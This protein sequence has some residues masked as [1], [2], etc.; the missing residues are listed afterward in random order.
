MPAPSG[1]DGAPTAKP[2]V[3]K[4]SLWDFE[5]RG[6]RLAVI[7]A[8]DFGCNVCGG[9]TGYSATTGSTSANSRPSTRPRLVT[10]SAGMTP[11]DRNETIMNGYSSAQPS[12]S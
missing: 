11:S 3:P 4:E 10:R 1:K 8:R 5:D 7:G 6:R 9:P 12:S 2:L